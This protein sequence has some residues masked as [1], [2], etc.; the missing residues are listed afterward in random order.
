MKIRHGAIAENIVTNLC[1][2]FNDDRLW[3]EKA[4]VHWKSDDN[5]NSNNKNNVGSTWGP[6]SRSNKFISYLLQVQILTDNV[7]TI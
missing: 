1:A 3:N 5:K 7:T 4:L 6:V 2:K